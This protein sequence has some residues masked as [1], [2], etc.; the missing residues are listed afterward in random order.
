MMQEKKSAIRKILIQN[1]VTNTETM[2]HVFQVFPDRHCIKTPYLFIYVPFFISLGMTDFKK[3]KFVTFQIKK[4]TVPVIN[5]FLIVLLT[6]INSTI[7]LNIYLNDWLT[8]WL[9]K[10]FA[11]WPLLSVKKRQEYLE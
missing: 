4:G 3:E 5:N 1:I 2:N 11:F 9:K 7:Q 8:S 10:C 6:M